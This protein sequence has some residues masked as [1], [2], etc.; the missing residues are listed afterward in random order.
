MSSKHLKCNL[1]L[2]TF[3]GVPSLILLTLF[4]LQNSR[5]QELQKAAQRPWPEFGDREKLRNSI[6]NENSEDLNR[7]KRNQKS[8]FLL[9]CGRTI[10]RKDDLSNSTICHL[11]HTQQILHLIWLAKCPLELRLYTSN[12]YT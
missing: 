3:S 6:L 10:C 5:M 8:N 11:L 12:M 1:T 4:M 9:F 7:L 2:L